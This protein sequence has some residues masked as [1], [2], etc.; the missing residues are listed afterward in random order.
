MIHYK[1]WLALDRTGIITPSEIRMIH[2]KISPLSVSIADIF[3][4]TIDEIRNEFS[5]GEKILSA[6]GQAV[7]L[8]D[9][10][11]EEYLS[12][13]EAGV[14]VT[15]VFEPEFPEKLSNTPSKSSPS[16]I[17]SIGN[18]SLAKS[19]CAAII[20]GE[21]NSPKGNSIAQSA[22]SQFAA[23]EITV[24][25]ALP[26]ETVVSALAATLGSGGKVISVLPGGILACELPKRIADLFDPQR[27]LILSPFRPDESAIPNASA[28]QTATLCA[29]SRAVFVVETPDNETAKTALSTSK[30]MSVPLFAA[31]YAEYPAEASGNPILIKNGAVPV[32]GKKDE[33]GIVP[34]LENIIAAVRK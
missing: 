33:S 19:P 26:S 15:M 34:N 17:F 18:I 24:A 14:R 16:A 22:A 21:K 4:C 1:Y 32:R 5:F 23:R 9:S 10:V 11:E 25:G 31:E 20:S 12:L 8:I 3:S 29:V 28:L 2:E 27:T 13:V 7:P 6:I 30:A